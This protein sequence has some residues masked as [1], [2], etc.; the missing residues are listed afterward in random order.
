MRLA[1]GGHREV[2]RSI[3]VAATH[4]RPL[5]GGTA[6]GNAANAAAPARLGPTAIVGVGDPVGTRHASP[7][8]RSRR[9]SAWSS[10]VVERQDT[11]ATP[12]RWASQRR[13]MERSRECRGRA[14]S[15]RWQ[16][17]V[18]VIE[19]LWLHLALDAARALGIA[20]VL[21][22]HNVER[23]VTSRSPP[24]PDPVTGQPAVEG[25]AVEPGRR[26]PVSSEPSELADP[27]VEVHRGCD[28][29]VARQRPR[30]RGRTVLVEGR[31]PVPYRLRLRDATDGGSPTRRVIEAG[32][33]DPGG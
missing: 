19:Q 16:P 11:L 27:A 7:L 1:R 18:V 15:R 33:R 17:D 25:L 22:A 9:R 6:L 23:A 26:V 10:P 4:P 14:F 32:R 28:R 13:S 5:V 29:G 2:V 8:G 20:T 24:P 21:D 30:A 31:W 3:L 12:T